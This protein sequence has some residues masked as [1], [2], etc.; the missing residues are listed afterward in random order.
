[1]AG[2]RTEKSIRPIQ[3]VPAIL[4][5]FVLMLASTALYG[6]LNFFWGD[7]AIVQSPL[8]LTGVIFVRHD[9]HVS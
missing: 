8:H 4:L 5:T 3:L 7:P 1:M 2:K 9:Q 6:L